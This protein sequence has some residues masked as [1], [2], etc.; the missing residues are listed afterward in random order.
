MGEKQKIYETAHMDWMLGG[1]L[2]AN[3]HCWD[4]TIF[5]AGCDNFKMCTFDF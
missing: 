1:K 3:E 5:K 2:W 4:D